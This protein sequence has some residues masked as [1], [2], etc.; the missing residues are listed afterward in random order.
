[1]ADDVYLREVRDTDLP[2]FFAFQQDPI[3]CKMAAF[4]PRELEAFLAHWKKIRED[5]ALRTRTIVCG[6]TVVGN[7]AC[8]DRSGQRLVGYW[9]GREYWGRGYATRGL[10]ALLREEP[11]RP[12]HAYVALHNVASIRVLEKCGFTI[13]E[14]CKGPAGERGEEV[15]EVLMTLNL[16]LP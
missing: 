3:A 16:E 11:R 15:D 7:V 6:D 4:K 14:H 12:L 13:T 2:L 5:S 8:F 1:M 10:R 9:I